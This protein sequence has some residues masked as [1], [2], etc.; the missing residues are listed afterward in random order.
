MSS[1]S[2]IEN[3]LN[4]LQIEI[5]NIRKSPPQAIVDKTMSTVM[6]KLEDRDRIIDLELKN[7]GNSI[8]LDMQHLLSSSNKDLELKIEKKILAAV[9]THKEKISWGMEILRFAVVAVMFLVSLKV[10]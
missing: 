7:L 2:S 5:E 9:G 10:L 8:K 6:Q 1:N 3:R 4:K